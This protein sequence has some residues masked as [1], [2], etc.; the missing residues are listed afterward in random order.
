MTIYKIKQGDTLYSIS[1]TFGISPERISSDN[2]L[3]PSES[4]VPGKELVILFPSETYAVKE[5]DTL[6]SVASEFGTTVNKL[7]RNNPILEGNPLIYPGQT[8]IISYETE[9][10]REIIVN[11]YAYPFIEDSVLRR[12]LPYLTYL[13]VFT[14]GFKD[15]GELIPADDARMLELA[16]AYGVS[17]LLLVSTLGEDGKFN[18]MLSSRLFDDPDFENTFITNLVNTATE[19]GYGG[20]EVDF[21][22]IPKDDA[23]RYASFLRK[24]YDSANTAGLKL[25]VA[26][27]PKISADQAGLLYE[28]HDY[29][30]IGEIADYVIL[31]TY[32]WGY[33]YG[34]PGAV[35]PIN[36]VEQV[37]SYAVTEIAPE[38]ILLGIPNYGYDWKLP[39]V[40]GETAA[41][42]L[43]NKIADSRAGEV[44]AEILFD[45]NSAAPYYTYIKDGS[46]HIVWFENATS[47]SKKL[48][49]VEK[50]NLAGISIWQIM[51]F[52]PQLYQTLIGTFKF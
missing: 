14:Y 45:E 13:T 23:A 41:E 29:R 15:G 50:Y 34:P 33:Q 4:L 26:L 31:M 19:M 46:E 10:E 40:Q 20:I 44:G 49:L 25:F 43:S 28:G 27:A 5:G 8:L 21:E 37:V 35:A 36:N 47:I 18:N 38:K 6:F 51:R 52:Y 39:F 11:G 3:S 24:L 16:R 22:F 42:G 9:N 7:L 12:T 2:D 17:P 30:A 1:Q 48:A 32:E